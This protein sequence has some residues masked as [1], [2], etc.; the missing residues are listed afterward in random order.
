MAGKHEIT[1]GASQPAAGISFSESI[2]SRIEESIEAKKALM[3][4]AEMIEEIA[5]LIIRV[6]RSGGKVFLF[7]N[8]GSAADAQHIAAELSGKFYLERAPLPAE[9]LNT[10]TSAVTAIANDYSFDTV[11]AR[12]LEANGREGD[13]AIGISTSGNS[14]NIIEGL[15]IARQKGIAAVALTGR[16]GGDLKRVTDLCLS[17]P[18]DDT[19][20]I[21][22]CHILV[23]HIVCELVERELFYENE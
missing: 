11:F 5:R 4:Q 1:G 9:A 19:A 10:N 16:D 18:S 7:G 23:G 21:Q 17:V 22:E 20:R 2:R 15:K 12:Q 14:I 3:G 6:Y 8:G 13:V